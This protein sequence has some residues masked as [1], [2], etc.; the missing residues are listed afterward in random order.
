LRDDQSDREPERRTLLAQERTLLA[1]WRSGLAALTVA[2]AVGRLLPALLGGSRTPFA[3][4]GLGFAILGAAFII[5]GSAR[6]RMIERGLA[7]GEF[8]AI[9]RWAL[10]GFTGF[11]TLLALVTIVLSAED[12]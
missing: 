8:R 5:Y 6:D 11:M 4:L 10:W 2:L 1:W 9:D 12:L 3:F 7:R